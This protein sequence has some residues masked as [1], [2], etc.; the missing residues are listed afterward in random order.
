MN[1]DLLGDGTHF[2]SGVVMVNVP[3]GYHEDNDYAEGIVMTIDGNDWLAYTDPDDGYRSYGCLRMCNG[4]FN[5]PQFPA[6]V[7]HIKNYSEDGMDDSGWPR[8]YDKM[9]MTGP[10]GR[11]IMEI[12]TD[13]SDSWYPCSMF[14]Y[15]PENLPINEGRN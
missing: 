2:F 1:N 15:N 5:V 11:L 3:V 6:Q 4:E 8:K 10:N 13:H 14:H 12:G 7:V 9:V